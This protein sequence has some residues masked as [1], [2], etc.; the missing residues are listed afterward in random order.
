MFINP[1]LPVIVPPLIL[2]STNSLGVF[3]CEVI[4]FTIFVVSVWLIPINASSS[5]FTVPPFTFTVALI[6]P[7]YPF[8][9]TLTVP[10][11]TFTIVPVNGIL[12]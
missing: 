7:K 9:S 6:P 8:S 11:F 3:P 1:L 10:P 5:R 12:L 4:L 2:I